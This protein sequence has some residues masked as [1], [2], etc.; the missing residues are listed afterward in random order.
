MKDQILSFTESFPPVHKAT[1]VLMNIDY[2]KR[3]H[4]F[5]NAVVIV[6]AF[7]A[8]IATVLYDKWMQNNMNERIQLVAMNVYTWAKEVALPKM[9]KLYQ[10]VVMMYKE[11]VEVYNIFKAGL[12]IA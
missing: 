3:F 9:K 11:I 8:A 4:Q 1:E 7:V 5:M 6:C 2:K 10:A 12:V